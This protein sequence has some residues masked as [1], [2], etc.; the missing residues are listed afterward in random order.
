MAAPVRKAAALVPGC[1]TGIGRS[2]ALALHEA[3]HPVCATARQVASLADLADRGLQVLAL[4]VPDEASMSA[5]VDAVAAQHG[6][7]GVLVNNAGY[8]LQGSIEETPL[9]EV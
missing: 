3:G 7:V 9:A 5:A 4:D 2:T 8:S 1:S 6:S